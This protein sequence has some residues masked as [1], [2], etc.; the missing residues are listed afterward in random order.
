MDLRLLHVV[1]DEWKIQLIVVYGLAQ[2]NPGAQEFNDAIL[3]TATQRV[4]QVNLPAIIL[5]DFNADV[6]KLSSAH[7]LA[8]LGFLHLQQLYV[9]MYG[10]DMPPSCKEATNPDTAFISPVLLPRLRSISVLQE[11]LFDA[12]KVALF[13]L[14]GSSGNVFKQVWPKPRPF[15]DLINDENLLRQANLDLSSWP[16]QGAHLPRHLPKAFGADVSPKSQNRS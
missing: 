5:G 8:N 4:Q 3:A 13:D 12:H 10:C 16:E 6:A 7:K 9:N 14:K 1:I 15:T 11:P 2:S